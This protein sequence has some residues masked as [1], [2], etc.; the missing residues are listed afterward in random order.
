MRRQAIGLAEFQPA[1]QLV[2]G[3]ARSGHHHH[4]ARVTVLGHDTSHAQI[5]L[6]VGQTATTKLMQLPASRRCCYRYCIHTYLV[7]AAWNACSRSAIKSSLSSR[8]TETLS[9]LSEIPAALRASGAMPAWVMVAVW[10]I[11]LSTPPRDSARVNS[12]N[13][14]RKCR[15]RASSP[16]NS[17]LIMAPK[18]YC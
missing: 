16:S 8:P 5:T 15:K 4:V 3:A 11:R 10:E 2:R 18:P 7:A 9:R 13:W 14:E 17:K 1:D 12:F 6:H